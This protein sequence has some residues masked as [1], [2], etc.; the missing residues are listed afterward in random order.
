[1]GSG[2][3]PAGLRDCHL[4]QGPG[5]GMSL[6]GKNPMQPGS[7]ANGKKAPV[8]CGERWDWALG[9]SLTPTSTCRAER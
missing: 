2:H 3:L 5:R 4:K 8:G 7:W 1:M 9:L 6:N